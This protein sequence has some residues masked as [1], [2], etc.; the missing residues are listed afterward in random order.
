MARGRGVAVRCLRPLR[1]RYRVGTAEHPGPVADLDTVDADT[2]DIVDADVHDPRRAALARRGDDSA[3][4][5]P[6]P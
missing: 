2:V 5:Q 1:D 4:G 3:A 6:Q